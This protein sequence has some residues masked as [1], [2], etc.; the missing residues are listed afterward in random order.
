MSKLLRLK[1]G[2]GF[3]LIELMITVAI[4]AILAAI[5]LPAYQDQVMRSRRAAAQ[6]CLV[7]LSQFMERHY[8]T[9]M[10]YSGAVLPTTQCRTDLAAWYTF[11]FPAGNPTDTTFTIQAVAQGV[12][13]TRDTNCVTQTLTQTGARSPAA[14]CWQ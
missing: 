8:T 9:H 7:E 14:G 11:S 5:A 3:T 2:R 13:A 12:Q 10:T 1:Q 4:V 6:A